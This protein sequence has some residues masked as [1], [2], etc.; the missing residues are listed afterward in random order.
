MMVSTR[1]RE[2][3]FSLKVASIAKQSRL[4]TITISSA[5]SLILKLST[6]FHKID[7][8]TKEVIKDVGKKNLTKRSIISFLSGKGENPYLSSDIIRCLRQNHGLH[9]PDS[10]L[11]F[12]SKVSSIKE[13]LISMGSDPSL[14]TETSSSIRRVFAR[15]SHV[16]V[17]LER[18]KL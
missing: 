12:S 9:V 7:I 8:L 10:L 6:N 18:L 17:D 4:G 14:D 16:E 15:F 11:D 2:E 5:A 13:S 3:D 1:S